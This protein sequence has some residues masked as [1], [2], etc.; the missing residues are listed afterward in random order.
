[1]GRCSCHECGV[2]EEYYRLKLNVYLLGA[3]TARPS[4]QADLIWV[5]RHLERLHGEALEALRALL[6]HWK[7]CKDRQQSD[8]RAALRMHPD[9]LELELQHKSAA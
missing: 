4:R 2:F 8:A 1:M 5:R 6:S 3:K 9:Q 7:A